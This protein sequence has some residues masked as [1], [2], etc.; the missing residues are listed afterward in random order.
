MVKL[1]RRKR[2]DVVRDVS[3]ARNALGFVVVVCISSGIER[4]LMRD[5]DGWLVKL[6]RWGPGDVGREV[7]VA[8]DALGV[9]VVVCISSGIEQL[10]TRAV[11]KE[12]YPPPPKSYLPL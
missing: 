11:K 7:G 10:L 4:R 5:Y 2:D 6:G 3:V 9:V 12:I 8:G 1:G